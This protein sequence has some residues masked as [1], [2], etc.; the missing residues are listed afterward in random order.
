MATCAGTISV[1]K[2]LVVDDSELIR[3]RLVR[4]IM[5]IP[6]VSQVITASGQ[7]QAEYLL[8]AMRPALVVLDLHLPDGDPVHLIP[9]FKNE[10]KDLKVAVLTNDATDY[11]RQRCLQAGADWFFDKSTEFEQLL[12]QLRQLSDSATS[13]RFT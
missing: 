10:G 6:G 7:Q 8:T 4:Q 12:V 11:N 2:I 5:A 3:F 1:M 13:R 9:K